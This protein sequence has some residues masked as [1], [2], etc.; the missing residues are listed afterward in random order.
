MR[1]SFRL[2]L[3]FLLSKSILRKY[4]ELN[5]KKDKTEIFHAYH[6]RLKIGYGMDEWPYVFPERFGVNRTS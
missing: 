6:N 1:Q 2:P 3:S 4:S 5:S